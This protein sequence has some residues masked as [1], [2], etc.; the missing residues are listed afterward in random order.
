MK[1]NALI[2]HHYIRRA[3]S[4]SDKITAQSLLLLLYVCKIGEK[5][6][7]DRLHKFWQETGLINN[8]Q[9]GFLKG[10]PTVTQL[11]SS[12]SDWAK[13]RNLS[14]PT[15]VVFLDLAKAFDSVP[16][17]RLLLKLK[18]NGIDGRLN[19]WLSYFLT[20]RRQRVILR[21]TRSNWSSVTSG[22]PQG[23]ILGPLLFFIYINDI[24]NC[25]SSTVKLYADDTKIYRQIVDPIKDPQLLP[26]D[27]SNL[28][29][30][31]R[32]WQLRFN[33][34]KRMCITYTRD[35]SIT[36]YML[37]KPLKDVKS[38]KDLGVTITKDLSCSLL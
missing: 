9:F 18:S 30:W 5:N 22:T 12:L 19:A 33:A 29:E 31:A 2:S 6:V 14:R 8:N 21:G 26:I 3:L 15:D 34:D 16:H 37:D 13:S 17:K 20:G 4:L 27:L 32:N 23:T 1:G 10:R 24:T 38:F 11:L 25:V 28:M 36:Q 35:K 7:F